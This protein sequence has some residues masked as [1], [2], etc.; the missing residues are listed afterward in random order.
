V[1][2]GRLRKEARDEIDRPIRFLDETERHMAIDCEPEDENDAELEEDD[3]G[4]HDGTLEPSM[5]SLDGQD[6]Q[7]VWAMGKGVKSS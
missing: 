5:G 6:N 2:Q 1:F 3:P 7:I 4:E